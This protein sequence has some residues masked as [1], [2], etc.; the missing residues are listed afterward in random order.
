[1]LPFEFI[2]AGPPLSHQTRNRARLQAWKEKV[3]AAAAAQWPTGTPPVT[4]PVKITVVYYHEREAI[5]LDNDN[6]VKPL[7]DAL[8]RL[9]YADDRMITDTVARKTSIDGEFR[10]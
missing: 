2:V 6:M 1:M 8:N 5:R 4:T 3:R 9:I 7:Q 10:V